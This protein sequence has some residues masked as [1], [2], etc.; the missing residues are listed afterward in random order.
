MPS[1]LWPYTSCYDHV[2]VL[3]AKNILHCVLIHTEFQLSMMALVDHLMLQLFNKQSFM[4][5][6][7]LQLVQLLVISDQFY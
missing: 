3:R 4:Y 6:L 5:K 1:S 2:M 7:S